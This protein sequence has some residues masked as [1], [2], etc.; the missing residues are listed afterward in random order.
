MLTG[1]ST[2]EFLKPKLRFL[3]V[4]KCFKPEGENFGFVQTAGKSDLFLKSDL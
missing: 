2:E 1:E 4:N 3:C